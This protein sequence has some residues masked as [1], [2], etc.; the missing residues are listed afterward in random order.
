MSYGPAIGA[1]AVTV[2]SFVWY[3]SNSRSKA[4]T[5]WPPWE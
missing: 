3:L 5:V 2:N 1:Q 4:I